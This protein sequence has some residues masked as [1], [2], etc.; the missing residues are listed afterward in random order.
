MIIYV[1]GSCTILLHY[2]GG[3]EIFGHQ[4]GSLFHPFGIHKT[5]NF[6]TPGKTDKIIL[7]K[8]SAQFLK[9]NFV[10]QFFVRISRNMTNVMLLHPTPI[11]KTGH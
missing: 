9:N 10:D 6:S 5:L 3:C 4:V 2:G 1:L 7:Q 11:L 8:Y